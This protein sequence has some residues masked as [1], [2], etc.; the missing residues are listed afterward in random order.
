METTDGTQNFKNLNSLLATQNT[1]ETVESK[2]A[3]HKLSGWRDY[4]RSKAVLRSPLPPVE[5][6]KHGNQKCQCFPTPRSSGTKDVFASQGDRQTFCLN[7]SHI[8][9]EG[10]LETCAILL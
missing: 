4:Q 5:D 6:L 8:D 10:F 9:E 3:T 7:I 2:R 1:G